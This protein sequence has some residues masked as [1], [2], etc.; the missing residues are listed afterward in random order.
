MFE[1]DDGVVVCVVEYGRDFIEFG[2]VCEEG[3][4]IGF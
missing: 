4:L 1:W 3:V 2:G